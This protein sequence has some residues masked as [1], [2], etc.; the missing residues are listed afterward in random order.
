[1]SVT[2]EWTSVL[3]VAT[4]VARNENGPMVGFGGSLESG[5]WFSVGEFGR[6]MDS[7][8]VNVFSYLI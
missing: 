6:N 1:M 8:L 3:T 2:L 4:S 7:V 5:D